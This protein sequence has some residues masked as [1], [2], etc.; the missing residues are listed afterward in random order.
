MIHFCFTHRGNHNQK[1]F[2]I[3][4]LHILKGK[5]TVFCLR[6]CLLLDEKIKPLDRNFLWFSPQTYLQKLSSLPPSSLPHVKWFLLIAS[7]KV[8][9]FSCSP[10]DSPVTDPFS[11]LRAH[12]LLSLA[13]ASSWLTGLFYWFWLHQVYWDKW[14]HY[15]S[16][17]PH[18]EIPYTDILLELWFLR[19]HSFSTGPAK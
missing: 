8:L 17:L 2:M 5:K 11:P 10:I 15:L 14:L 13:S 7:F 16:V 9:G 3:I 18:S 12:T 1:K 19:Q 4:M 6:N